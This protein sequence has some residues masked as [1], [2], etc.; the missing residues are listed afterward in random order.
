MARILACQE[1]PIIVTRTARRARA[2]SSSRGDVSDA[3]SDN[4]PDDG[5]NDSPN[6]G[7]DDNSGYFSEESD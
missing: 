7:S 5:Y 3:A 2:S 4:G 6:D 1:T